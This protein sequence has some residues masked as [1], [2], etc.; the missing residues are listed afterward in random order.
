MTRKPGVVSDI[1]T[2][3]PC[4]QEDLEINERLQ[5]C[6]LLV[7]GIGEENGAY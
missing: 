3:S 2:T 6:A 1:Q 5:H 4:R 7:E